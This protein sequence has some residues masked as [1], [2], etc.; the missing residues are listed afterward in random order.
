M[1]VTLRLRGLVATFAVLTLV[2]AAWSTNKVNLTDGGSWTDVRN[3]SGSDVAD[4]DGHSTTY[5]WEASSGPIP[6][7]TGTWNPNNQTYYWG[8]PPEEHYM[9]FEPITGCGHSDC[10]KYTSDL[11]TGEIHDDYACHQEP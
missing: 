1:R 2:T 6:T 7:H 5:E 3:S 9:F 11:G 10:F 4:V 8:E